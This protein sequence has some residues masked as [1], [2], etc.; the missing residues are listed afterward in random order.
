MM[1]IGIT[2]QNGFIGTHLI[3]NLILF[4][5]EF[6]IINF[7]RSFCDVNRLTVILYNHASPPL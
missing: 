4:P 1:K 5:K 7:D 2:G 6:E 3:N